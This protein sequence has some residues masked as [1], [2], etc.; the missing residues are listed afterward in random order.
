MAGSLPGYLTGMAGTDTPVTHRQPP[1]P[2]TLTGAGLDLSFDLD[3][4]PM[5]RPTVAAHAEQLGMSGR[6]LANL[7]VVASELATNAIRHGG[8]RGRL[9]LWRQGRNVNCQVRDHGSGLIDPHAGGTPPDP[10]AVHGRGLWIC[11]QICLNLII[12]RR[13]DGRPGASVTAVMHLGS[14]PA[15]RPRSRT[16]LRGTRST[17]H[18]HSVPVQS[19]R[20]RP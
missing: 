8:G 5:L 15:A 1:R 12:S 19:A 9:R 20:P 18:D 17:N 16:P 7:L 13:D 4:L 6:P 3:N 11:R 2:R 10:A 14:D